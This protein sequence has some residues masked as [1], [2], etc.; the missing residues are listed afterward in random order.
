MV[1]MNVYHHSNSADSRLHL[2]PTNIDFI[3]NRNNASAAAHEMGTG[4]GAAA[5][6]ASVGTVA[7]VWMLGNVV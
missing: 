4:S 1:N 3:I 5:V 7:V 2:Y 6:W